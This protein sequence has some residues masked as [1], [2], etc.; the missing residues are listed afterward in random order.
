VR[1]V[2][3]TVVGHVSVNARQPDGP[4]DTL[5]IGDEVESVRVW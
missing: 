2:H 4:S 5:Y 1:G 3:R